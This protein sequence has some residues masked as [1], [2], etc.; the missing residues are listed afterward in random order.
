LP[1]HPP[2]N[3]EGAGNAGC[4]MHPQ[5]RARWVVEVC[6]RVFTAEAPETSGIPHAMVLRRMAYSPRRRIR[7]ASVAGELTTCPHPVGPTRL[8]RLDTSNGC[9][10]HTLLPSA[11]APF[12]LRARLTR[13]RRKPPCDAVAPTLPASTASHPNVRDDSRSAPRRRNGMA[14]LIAAIAISAN[15]NLFSYGAGQTKSHH[16]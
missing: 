16:I 2:S 15:Q 10:D 13:S 11:S 12:V 1:N 5:P 9:Q 3:D 4:S 14:W 8:R 7:L 6:A